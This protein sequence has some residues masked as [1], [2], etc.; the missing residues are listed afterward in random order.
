MMRQPVSVLSAI[1]FQMKCLN[2]YAQSVTDSYC[3]SNV[4]IVLDRFNVP[5]A[6]QRLAAGTT[7][8]FVNF[9]HP[10]ARHYLPSLGVSCVARYVN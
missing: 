8:S 3:Q 7:F 4:F 10:C 5:C 1:C 9:D 6:Q 2:S